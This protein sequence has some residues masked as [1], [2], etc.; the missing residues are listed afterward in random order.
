MDQSVVHLRISSQDLDLINRAAD[1][2][3]LTISDWIVQVALEE[4]RWIS[5]QKFSEELIAELNLTE[6]SEEYRW[7]NKVLGLSAG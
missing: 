7:A 6:D 5:A 1:H 2:E 3:G 4:A